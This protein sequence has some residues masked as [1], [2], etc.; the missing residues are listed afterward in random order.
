MLGKMIVTLIVRLLQLFPATL[1]YNFVPQLFFM[2]FFHV[3]LDNFHIFSMQLVHTT[4]FCHFLCIFSC[5]WFA[6]FFIQFPK[7]EQFF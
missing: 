1:L 4:F 7:S 6:T 2:D 3:V 5:K